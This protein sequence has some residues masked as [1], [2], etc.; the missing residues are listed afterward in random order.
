MNPR[1]F[2]LCLLALP[3]ACGGEAKIY[4]DST[5]AE[6]LAECDDKGC[7]G[8]EGGLPCGGTPAF[9]GASILTVCAE[10]DGETWSQT[11]R[12]LRCKSDDD[13]TK[14]FTGFSCVDD[15]YCHRGGAPL[16]RQD[17][18]AFCLATLPSLEG[19]CIGPTEEVDQAF[20][21]VDTVCPYDGNLTTL[22]Q[23]IPEECV[24]PD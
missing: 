8:V 13:C 12:P 5:G 15:G 9:S 6:V 3:V 21:L 23:N 4:F 20:Q 24:L 18:L 14:I 17:A 10:V 1:L 19:S 16:Y 22:C 2:I 7:L 11:C